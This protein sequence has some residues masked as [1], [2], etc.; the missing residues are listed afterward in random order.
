MVE[1]FWLPFANQLIVSKVITMQKLLGALAMESEPH[2]HSSTRNVPAVPLVGSSWKFHILY[3]HGRRRRRPELKYIEN[4]GGS[5]ASFSMAK[6]HLEPS[7][8]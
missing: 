3:F 8:S 7:G 4:I 6:A 2:R 1:S 5:M